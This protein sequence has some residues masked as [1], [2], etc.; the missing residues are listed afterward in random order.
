MTSIGMSKLFTEI[1]I[2]IAAVGF[3]PGIAGYAWAIGWLPVYGTVCHL[4]KIFGPTISP[5]GYRIYLLDRGC[6]V[7][8]A[9]R[10]ILTASQFAA[11]Q[12]KVD[13]NKIIEVYHAKRLA[14]PGNEFLAVELVQKRLREFTT[15]I[16]D[17]NDCTPAN[18]HCSTRE[19][20]GE[21]FFSA[22]LHA[23][24]SYVRLQFRYTVIDGSDYLT[25]LLR[26]GPIAQVIIAFCYLGAVLLAAGFIVRRIT[27]QPPAAA[28]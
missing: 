16:P 8:A 11:G 12:D 20:S 21:D 17:T 2:L 28:L 5:D 3:F 23:Y 6:D 13:A 26:M 19:S 27:R 10:N 15:S 7:D 22:W 4:D 9:I 24:F 14:V 1:A 25:S 18:R